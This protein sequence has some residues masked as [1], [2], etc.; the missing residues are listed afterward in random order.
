M[1]LQSPSEIDRI[2]TGIVDPASI[3][4]ACSLADIGIQVYGDGIAIKDVRQFKARYGLSGFTTNPTLVAQAGATDYLAFAAR[5]LEVVPEDPVSFEVVADDYSGMLRQ[6]HILSSLGDNVFVKIPVVN[7][8]CEGSYELIRT[9]AND[10]IALN[11]TAVFTVEQIE[12]TIDVLPDNARAV[13]SIFAGRIAD[14][15][16]DPTEV[17]KYAVDVARSQRRV[18]ILWASCRE[19]FNILQASQAGCDIVTVPP[20]LLVKTNSFGKD[21]TEFSRETVEMFSRDAA[22]S[23]FSF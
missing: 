12:R 20:Q 4:Q 23:G 17:V 2:G 21:L 15:G 1:V 3:V 7:T 11:I 9:L 6:A 8:K 14:A 10:E 5:F 18:E 16:C 22:N 13:I 19:V